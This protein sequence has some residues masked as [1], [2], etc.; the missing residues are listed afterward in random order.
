MGKEKRMTFPKKSLHES[1][2]VLELVHTDVCGPMNVPSVGGSRYFVSFV[3]DFSRIV[4]VYML[5]YKSDVLEKFREYVPMA[6]KLTGKP[7]KSIRSDNGGEYISKEIIEYCRARSGVP[8]YGQKQF[9]I[10][11]Q[12]LFSRG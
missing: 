1:T 3:D 2:E 4:Y 8:L 10:G 6:E 11:A 5:K 9:V 12:R 7:I